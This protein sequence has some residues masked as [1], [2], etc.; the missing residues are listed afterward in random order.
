MYRGPGPH[1]FVH[2]MTPQLANPSDHLVKK[3]QEYNTTEDKTHPTNGK[4]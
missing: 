3:C 4:R 2:R 1:G